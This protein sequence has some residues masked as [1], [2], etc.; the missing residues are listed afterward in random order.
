MASVVVCSNCGKKSS[1]RKN[2]HEKELIVILNWIKLG[3]DCYCKECMF[4]YERG[5]DEK[6]ER[7]K[8]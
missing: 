1:I 2:G 7:K 4:G 5:V 3:D 8:V 6:N